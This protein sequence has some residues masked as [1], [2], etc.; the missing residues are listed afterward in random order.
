LKGINLIG[1]ARAEMG[2]GE[3]CRATAKALQCADIPFGIIDY[4]IGNYSRM[5]D[6]SWAEKELVSPSYHTNIIHINADQLLLAYRYLGRA[7]FNSHF[8]IGYWAW[9]LPEFPSEYN[10]SFSMVQEVW[11][12]SSF[13]LNAVS[14]NSPVPVVRI[15]PAIEVHTPSFVDRR[16]FGLNPKQFLFLSMYDSHSYQ[17]RK[18]PQAVIEAFRRAFRSDDTSVGLV[19]KINNPNTL[20]MQLEKLKEDIMGNK[21]IYLIDKI[22]SRDDTNSLLNTCDSLVSLHRSEGFGLPLA[23]AMYLG[24]PVIGTLWSGVTDFMNNTNSCG[25]NYKLV[26]VGKDYGPY[27]SHQLW[28]E[29]DIEHAAFFM[30]KLVSDSEWR[31]QI[32]V[33]GQNTIR[34]DFSA[35]VVGKMMKE[36]LQNLGRL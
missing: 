27:K 21:N 22:L 35:K 14:K 34:T 25:V 15:P 24:K 33:G 3:S 18:N 30:K 26:H 7:I 5:L 1:Y 12:P 16:Y 2:L 6:F 11:V 8:N 10:Y 23:E 36:R 13:V 29:A 28:A 4:R 32:A 31:Q 19:L 20:P 17:A 9:E